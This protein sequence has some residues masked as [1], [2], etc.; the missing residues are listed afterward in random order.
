MIITITWNQESNS[1]YIWMCYGL[2]VKINRTSTAE[3]RFILHLIDNPLMKSTTT[4]VRVLGL[5]SY[6]KDGD[7]TVVSLPMSRRLILGRPS[8]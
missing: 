5:E 4:A 1:L 3:L 7:P 2:G 6:L 8:S